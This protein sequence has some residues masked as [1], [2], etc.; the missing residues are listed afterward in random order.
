M[1]SIDEISTKGV[2]SLCATLG[3]RSRD[4]K[5]SFISQKSLIV[6]LEAGANI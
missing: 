3:G 2:K 4:D 5:L 1:G 6:V